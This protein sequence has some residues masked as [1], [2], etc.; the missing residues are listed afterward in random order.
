MS[1]LE[2]LSGP[3][4]SNKLIVRRSQSVEVV[5]RHPPRP[6]CCHVRAGDLPPNLE[7]LPHFLP[8]GRRR[9]EVATG[10]KVL[11][12]RPLGCKEPL[13]MARGLESLHASLM[14]TGGPMRIRTPVIEIAALPML[15]AWHH[16]ALGSSVALERI[17]D[18]HAGT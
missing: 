8:V 13:R 9:Q 12:N 4:L 18:Q 7:A 15:Y 2:L 1:S 14:L 5:E 16:L 3:A 10:S 11:S 6:L 17:G